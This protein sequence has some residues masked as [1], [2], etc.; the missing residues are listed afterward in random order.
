M[1]NSFLKKQTS[2]VTEIGDNDSPSKVV[3]DPELHWWHDLAMVLI[4]GGLT[5]AEEK[6]LVDDLTQPHIQFYVKVKTEE[7]VCIY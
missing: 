5:D 4:K 7:S 3:T 1:S 6:A 2:L